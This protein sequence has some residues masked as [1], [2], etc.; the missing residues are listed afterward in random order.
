MLIPIFLPQ[1]PHIISRQKESVQK[2]FTC[3]NDVNELPYTYIIV[4]ELVVSPKKQR[5]SI[6]I[7]RSLSLL[8]LDIDIGDIYTGE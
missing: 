3:F 7:S 5:L 4:Y 1:P 8:L 6:L 2:L